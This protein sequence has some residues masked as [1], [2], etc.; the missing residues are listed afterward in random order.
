MFVGSFN[1]VAVGSDYSNM[2]E[3]TAILV[4]SGR[5]LYLGGFQATMENLQ[6]YIIMI[7][8]ESNEC[9]LLC[10]TSELHCASKS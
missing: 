5:F 3:T 2:P 1:L 10:F 6:S 8:D 7:L 9:S 4:K